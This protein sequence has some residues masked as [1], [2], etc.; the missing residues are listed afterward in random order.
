M[1]LGMYLAIQL[2]ANRGFKHRKWLRNKNVY[3]ALPS[4]KMRY[5]KEKTQFLLFFGGEVV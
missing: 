3:L 5:R 2:A 4:S 1:T